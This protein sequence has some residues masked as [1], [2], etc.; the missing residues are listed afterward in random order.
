MTNDDEARDALERIGLPAVIRPA[1]TLGGTGGGIAHTRGAVRAHRAGRPGG[2]P[3][4]PGAGRALAARLE[5]DRVRGDARRRRHLH[6]RLQ[7]GEPR[8]DGRA[9]RRQHRRRAQPDADRQGV[10][11]APDGVAED[12]PRAGH[13][14]RLQRP[15]RA[16]AAAGRRALGLA[17]RRRRERRFE[18]PPYYVI[19]VNPRVSRSS[20]LASKAT[21]YPIA[22]VAA[23]IAVGKTPRTRSRT[24]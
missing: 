15:V 23:K 3:D 14:G 2:Q 8:P 24:P 19:E 21:G 4:P 20:A 7:H 5:G 10:P 18:L 11:D 13:R 6:H 12:H 22:R 17:R 9:H 16:G 1:Y